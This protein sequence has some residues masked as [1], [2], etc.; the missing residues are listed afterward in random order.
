M[1]NQIICFLI[2]LLLPLHF[3]AQEDHYK[4]Q[5]I[6]GVEYYIYT[7]RQSEGLYRISVNFGVPQN[8]ILSVNPELKEG[9]KAGQVIFIPKKKDVRPSD[10]TIQQHKGESKKS[11]PVDIIA[12]AFGGSSPA[13]SPKEKTPI[14]AK[15]TTPTLQSKSEPNFYYHRIQKKETLYSLSKQYE[16]NQEDI[17]RYNPQA[18]AG[19][20]EGDILRIPKPEDIYPE[21]KEEKLQEDLSVKYLIHKVEP[22]ETLYSIGKKYQVKVDDILKINPDFEVLGIGQELRIPYYAGLITTE[23]KGGETTSFIDWDKLLEKKDSI[24]PSEKAMSIAFLLPFALENKND[25]SIA[26][27]VDFYGGAVLA[28]HEAKEKG[29]SLDIYTY[30]TGKTKETMEAIL[31][32]HPELKEMDLIV[33]PAY[34]AQVPVATLFA[35]QNEVKM[36]IPFTSKVMDIEYNPYVFQFNPGNEAEIEHLKH[37]FET[38][39]NNMNYIFADI[40]GIPVQDE[41]FT[42]SLQLKSIL[43]E[44]GKA[45]Q[46]LTLSYPDVNLF[47]SVAV[48]SKKNLIIFNTE[49]FGN[50][51]PYFENLN[52]T[53]R[54]YD[55]MLLEK[56]S[57]KS[58]NSHRPI[59]VYVSAFRTEYE[60]ENLEEYE[61]RFLDLL[62]W[63]AIEQNPRYD[64]LGYDLL[65]YFITLLN[66]EELDILS[67]PELDMYLEG[68]QSQFRFR[69][70]SPKSGFINQQ[71]YLGE[72]QIK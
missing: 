19:L 54:R 17:L 55:I 5:V 57:W 42:T 56:F 2:M 6:D 10:T 36:L 43:E 69:R 21:K 47:D 48:Y 44:Q 51:Q 14:V 18:K 31:T 9:L 27:F 22:K 28:I 33:G 34:T 60:M 66:N 37:L 20:R 16:V 23:T 29:I 71:V 72:S 26:R 1:K 7:V 40:E 41:G 15:N 11:A 63:K 70:N 8:E 24:I 68:L 32:N 50:V 38:K 59:G 30:D 45:Y 49:R 13:E 53:D 3:Y 25:A 46:T 61:E 62:G 67:A 39:L 35:R 58:Q 64:I 52:R 12:S 4:T 65:S